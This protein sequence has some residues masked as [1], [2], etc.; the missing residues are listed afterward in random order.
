VLELIRQKEVIAFQR[1]AFDDI[2]IVRN[3]EHEAAPQPGEAG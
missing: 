1:R 3:F 2:E